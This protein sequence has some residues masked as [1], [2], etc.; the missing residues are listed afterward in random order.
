M[1]ESVGE[2]IDLGAGLG[3]DGGAET[4]AE[5]VEEPLGESGEAELVEEPRGESG[6]AKLVE[7]PRG[8]SVEAELVEEPRESGEAELLE[9]PL[10]ESAESRRRRS[11]GRELEGAE[12][13]AG[14][15]DGERRVE[16]VVIVERE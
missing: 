9:E 15:D 7:E 14:V 16:R 3:V 5:L 10:E 6:E 2:S 8:E 13:G 1:S 4:E 11:G 12:L